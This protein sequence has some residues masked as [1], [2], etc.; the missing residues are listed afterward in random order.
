[1]DAAEQAQQARQEI[2]DSLISWALNQA[3]R[4]RLVRRALRAGV[5]KSRVNELT[6]I[7][8]TTIDRIEAGR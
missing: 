6:G 3:D 4:N 2:E 1:V 8:R 5:S 7:A